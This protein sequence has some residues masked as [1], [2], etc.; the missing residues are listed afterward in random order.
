MSKTGFDRLFKKFWGGHKKFIDPIGAK[1]LEEIIR[2]DTKIIREGFRFGEKNTGGKLKQWMG[3][4]K[5]ES[6][7]VV[8]DPVRGIGRGAATAALLY[9]A[10]AAAGGAAGGSGAGG[11]SGGATGGS[12]GGSSGGSA[13]GASSG[14]TASS[15]GKWG[16]MM[17]MG[18]RMFGQQQPPP[19]VVDPEWV[20]V[21]EGQANLYALSTKAAKRPAVG[22][23][24]V[25]ERGAKGGHPID[26]AG[27]QIGAI[28]ALNKEI[29]D[30]EA[31]IA[32]IKGAQR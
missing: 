19:D 28:K 31:R 25:L 14:S 7:E 6:S 3:D 26:A 32:K 12:A 24:A 11:A 8:R 17:Q 20:D 4:A 29:A 18:G 16:R 9:G 23:S 5:D 1:G 21:G 27:V 2:G 10:A 22:M 15:I 13:G 30:V